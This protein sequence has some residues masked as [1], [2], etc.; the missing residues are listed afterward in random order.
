[1]AAGVGQVM[2]FDADYIRTFDYH[3]PP[4]GG[5]GIDC[6]V[7]LLADVASIRDVLLRPYMQPQRA[8]TD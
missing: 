4:T 7:R 2:H 3:L 8:G 6:L 5:I 1:M